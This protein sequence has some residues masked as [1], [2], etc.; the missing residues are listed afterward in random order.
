MEAEVAWRKFG[1]SKEKKF[2]Y[3]N[4]VSDGDSST[5]SSLKAMIEGAGPYPGV[6]IDKIESLMPCTKKNWN[7]TKTTVG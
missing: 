1:R 5:F 6:M 4:M 2:I 3:E 7:K